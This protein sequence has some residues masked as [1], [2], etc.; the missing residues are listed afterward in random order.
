MKQLVAT[1][2]SP[3]DKLGKEYWDKIYQEVYKIA[4]TTN[5]PINT[6]N[7]V[8]IV[9]ESAGVYENGGVALVSQA[10]LK[11]MHQEDYL[12]LSRQREQNVESREQVQEQINKVASMVMKQMILP[13]I[14]LEVNYG[15]NFANLR[16]AYYSLILATWF[17][18]KLKESIYQ[19]YIDKEKIQGIDLED[20]EV[21]EKIYELYI[22]SFK[23]GVY[24]FVKTD[25][26]PGL[27]KNIKRRYHSGGITLASSSLDP[28]AGLKDIINIELVDDPKIEDS[29]PA[30]I[31]T[32]II[33][34]DLVEGDISNV[35]GQPVE[36]TGSSSLGLGSQELSQDQPSS[37]IPGGIAFKETNLDVSSG[38]FQFDIPLEIIRKFQA[39]SGLTF[40]ILRIEKGIDIDNFL[41]SER[42]ISSLP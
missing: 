31:F 26:E 19:Y 29:L 12:A 2:S 22:E 10:K 41:D 20:K 18:Q 7:K 5:L 36:F 32:T 17:K 37:E 34:N 23:K 8:W 6:F 25:H 4:G 13:E 21:R 1:L 30:N 14:D 40:K 15:K 11:A 42:K 33:Q 9:P 24:D 27:N 16:Q 39:S 38:S 28:D 3:Q 35:Q